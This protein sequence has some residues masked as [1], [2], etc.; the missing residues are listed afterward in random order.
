M[1]RSHEHQAAVI[2]LDNPRCRHRRRCAHRRP[3]AVR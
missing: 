3:V 2:G 1:M